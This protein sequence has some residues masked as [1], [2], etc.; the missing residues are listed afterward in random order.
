[1]ITY[2]PSWNNSLFLFLATVPFICSCNCSAWM[3]RDDQY[4]VGD[5]ETI[6]DNTTLPIYLP[7]CLDN[8]YVQAQRVDYPTI[9]NSAEE[10][11]SNLNQNVHFVVDHY[12]QYQVGNGMWCKNDENAPS[13]CFDYQVRFCCG[14]YNF[15]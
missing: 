7:P 2:I 13:G 4:G 5:Y 3:D 8:F 1:M 12:S 14:E 6:Q 15:I 9:Y 11:K 10:I